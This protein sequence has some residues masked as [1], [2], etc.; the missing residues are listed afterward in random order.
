MAGGPEERVDGALPRFSP[1]GRY[2]FVY[3]DAGGRGRGARGR[4]GRGPGGPGRDGR[5]RG[6]PGGRGGTPLKVDVFTVDGNRLVGN[7]ELP[8]ND[9]DPKWAASSDALTFLHGTSG[10]LS[11]WRQPIDGRPAEQ[12]TRFP[13]GGRGALYEWTRDGSLF[14]SQFQQQSSQVLL[15]KN[16]R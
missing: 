3:P 8:P 14:F 4:D 15:I 6:G 7:L 9:Q 1:D 16:F 11:I 13:P 5:A 2:Y 12:V 10:E